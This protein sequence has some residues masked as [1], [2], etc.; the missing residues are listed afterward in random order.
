MSLGFFHK[1]FSITLL[2]CSLIS[3]STKF[4][5]LLKNNDYL[6]RYREAYR[7]FERKKYD[8]AA[9]LFESVAPFYRNTPQD[10]SIQFYIAECFYLNKDYVSAAHY[11][12]TFSQNFSRSIFTET[13]DFRSGKCNYNMVPRTELDQSY[14]YK[15]ID[16]FHI[17]QHKYPNSEKTNECKEYLATLS[18][19]LAEKAH[20]AARLYFKV[21]EYKSAFLTFKNCLKDFPDSKYREEQL[22]YSLLSC[23]RLAELSI[24]D[25]KRE[26]HQLVIDEYLN[27]ISEFPD[28]KYKKEAKQIS[29]RSVDYIKRTEYNIIPFE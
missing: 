18:A 6:L 22:Y 23:Y 11:Y 24:V 10:D 21:G 29:D 16:A 12:T 2:F 25:K 7:H 5:K 20:K 17:Y 1:T 28:S 8:Q 26:R 14:A 9:M 27:L 19:H 15:A 13:A 4:E 3:C